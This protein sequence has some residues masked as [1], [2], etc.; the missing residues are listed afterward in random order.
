MSQWMYQMDD[1]SVMIRTVVSKLGVTVLQIS[2]V[3]RKA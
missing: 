2:E 3:F 1:G